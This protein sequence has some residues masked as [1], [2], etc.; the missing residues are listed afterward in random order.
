[1]RDGE[2]LITQNMYR[3]TTSRLRSEGAIGSE[4]AVVNKVDLAEDID[5]EIRTAVSAAL[6]G[7]SQGE[8]K[9]IVHE[10]TYFG[11]PGLLDTLR[12][13]GKGPPAEAVILDG[14][15]IARMIDV[16]VN[17][18]RRAELKLIQAEL[19]VG[20]EDSVKV[21]VARRLHDLEWGGSRPMPAPAGKKA[22][23]KSVFTVEPPK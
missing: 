7:A 19:A 23:E 15:Q 10:V 6:N 21:A 20:D 13:D 5:K 11:S 3:S 18:A 17:C 8:G 2:R 22:E 14:Q 16:A 9:A 1:M 12:K 4:S